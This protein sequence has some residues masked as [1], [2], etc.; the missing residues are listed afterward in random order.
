MNVFLSVVLCTICTA[1][2]RRIEGCDVYLC[3]YICMHV[4]I[5]YMC[6]NVA[7]RALGL[8]VACMYVSF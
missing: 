7:V 8:W 6:G 5:L 2:C 1:V 3:A 4:Y